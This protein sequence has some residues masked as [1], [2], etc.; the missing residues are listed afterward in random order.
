MTL[1][2]SRRVEIYVTLILGKAR[3][4]EDVP[5]HLKEVVQLEIDKRKESVQKTIIYEGEIP[6]F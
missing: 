5:E 1:L 2:E 6:S 4:M 3:N